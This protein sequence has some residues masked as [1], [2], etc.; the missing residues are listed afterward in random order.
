MKLSV[1]II[2]QLIF[3]VVLVMSFI[4]LHLIL[5]EKLNPFLTLFFQYLVIRIYKLAVLLDFV[6]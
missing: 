2:L 6:I 4:T 5:I 1:I 3:N